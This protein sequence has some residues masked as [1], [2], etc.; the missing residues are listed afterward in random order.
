[1]VQK[2][3]SRCCDMP[4]ESNFSAGSTM[5][6]QQCGALFGKAK[7]KPIDEQVLCPAPVP[8]KADACKINIGKTST[9]IIVAVLV[10]QYKM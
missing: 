5:S 10:L 3:T 1:M 8:T 4:A 6:T 7:F 2:M 9:V